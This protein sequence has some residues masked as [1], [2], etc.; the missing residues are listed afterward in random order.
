MQRRGGAIF[1]M[2]VLMVFEDGHEIRRKWAGGSRW[3]LFVE[4]YP[5]R[6]EYAVIDPD[7]ILALDI[8]PSNNSLQVEPESALPAWKW[9][10]RWT[11]WLEDFLSTF[12]FFV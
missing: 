12:A 4:E 3:R 11:V 10:A 2:E 6:L 5:A 9:A 8:H 1:P 7:R